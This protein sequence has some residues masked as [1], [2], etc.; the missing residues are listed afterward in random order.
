[1][2]HQPI[3]DIP[4]I[5]AHWERRTDPLPFLMVPMSDNTVVRYIPDCPQPAFV[6][7]MENVRKMTVGYK[8][9]GDA[10]TSTGHK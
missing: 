4:N 10:A 2:A 3:P 9:T 7:A 5:K 8:M 1:M 6:R